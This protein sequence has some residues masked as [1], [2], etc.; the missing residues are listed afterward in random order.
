MYNEEALHTELGNLRPKDLFKFGDTIYK[1]GHLINGTNSYVACVN[2]ET[3]KV[4][5]FYIGTKVEVIEHDWS[6]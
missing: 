3:H 2:T 1:V 6:I 5:R 4:T